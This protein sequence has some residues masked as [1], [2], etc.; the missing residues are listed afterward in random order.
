MNIRRAT[1]K[2]ISQIINLE[3]ERIEEGSR[4]NKER[5]NEI[6]RQMK[7]DFHDI[8]SSKSRILLLIEENKKIVAYLLGEIVI[9]VYQRSGKIEDIFV[10]Q[11]YRRMGLAQKIIK[12]FVRVLKI[13]EINKIKLDVNLKNKKAINLYKKL[14]FKIIQ[15]VMAK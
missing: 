10:S 3:K 5:W 12:E 6:I 9:T 4:I 8:I 14:G 1:K 15:Y 11:S 7:K 2:D 13:K